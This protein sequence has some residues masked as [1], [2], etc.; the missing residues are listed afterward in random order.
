MRYLL[1]TTTLIDHAMGRHGAP[2]V[3]ARLFSEPNDLYTCD[4]VVA[5]ALSSDDR[6]RSGPSSLD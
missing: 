4:V 3:I 5:E 6:P 2:E 1:D